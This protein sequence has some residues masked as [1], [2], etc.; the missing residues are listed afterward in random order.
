MLFCL[1]LKL[2][3]AFAGHCRTETSQFEVETA[4]IDL[5]GKECGNTVNELF[6]IPATLS[7]QKITAVV[8]D[9]N[10]NFVES[11]LVKCIR[12]GFT[13][14]K[15]KFTGNIDIDLEKTALLRKYIDNGYSVRVG[16]NNAF[17]SRNLTEFGQYLERL[18]YNFSAIEEPFEPYA[19]HA[20]RKITKI[21]NAPIVL[22]E[23]FLG[24]RDIERLIGKERFIPNVRISKLGGLVR[25]LR[26]VELT[27]QKK[28]QIILGSLVGETSILARLW[29]VVASYC[30]SIIHAAE[31]AYSTHL[32]EDDITEAPI[33]VKPPGLVDVPETIL[34]SPGLGINISPNAL[35]YLE[36]AWQQ[37]N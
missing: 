23:S 28:L 30:R 26:L 19:T 25:T 34:N 17:S 3:T 29:L 27:R 14:F 15:I 5:I 13:D 16:F 10:I 12:F 20:M 33:L 6:K 7:N 35:K 18:N 32:L 8:S 36:I 21:M 4:L 22:D 24:A 31:G 11:L 9:G 1:S 37:Q 2:T